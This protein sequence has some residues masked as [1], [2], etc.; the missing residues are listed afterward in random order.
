MNLHRS[1]VSTKVP[2]VCLGCG[3]AFWLKPSL[4]RA[5]GNYCSHACANTGAKGRPQPAYRRVGFY[6]RKRQHE[7]QA[8]GKSEACAR[9]GKALTFGSDGNGNV[10]Q[11]C[12]RCRLVSQVVRV[13]SA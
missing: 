1:F 8:E 4:V 7:P 12:E 13:R 2:R 10:F 3:A 11:E 6:S 9:C 5:S